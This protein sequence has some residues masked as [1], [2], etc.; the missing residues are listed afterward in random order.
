LLIGRDA[1]LVLDLSLDSFDG[2]RGF[3]VEGDGLSGE[4]LDEDLHRN[5]YEMWICR[6]NL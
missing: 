5:D 2:V 6:F 1:F 4:G 3:N